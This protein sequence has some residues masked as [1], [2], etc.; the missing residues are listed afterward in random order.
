MRFW[1]L[2]IFNVLPARMDLLFFFMFTL[3]VQCCA[4]FLLAYASNQAVPTLKI[5]ILNSEIITVPIDQA[6]GNFF[7][8]AWCNYPFPPNMSSFI[9]SLEISSFSFSC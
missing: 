2:V 3:S 1:H 8:V 9:T 5:I 7:Y 4:M 6:N